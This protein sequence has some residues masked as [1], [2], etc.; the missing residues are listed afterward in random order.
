MAALIGNRHSQAP[1]I[2]TRMQKVVARSKEARLARPPLHMVRMA[3]EL[4]GLRRGLG[5]IIRKGVQRLRRKP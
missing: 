1:G 3:R 2:N 5:R 4:F